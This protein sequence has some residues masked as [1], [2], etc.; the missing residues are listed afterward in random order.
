MERVKVFTGKGMPVK[1]GVGLFA[2]AFMNRFPLLPVEEEG[3]L[4]DPGLRENFIER[5][6]AMKDWRDT[7]ARGKTH[8]NLFGFHSRYKLLLLAHSERHARLLDR[9]VADAKSTRPSELYARYRE[10]FMAA[11]R[12]RATVRKNINVLRHTMGHFRK[13]ISADEKH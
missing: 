12:L 3:R 8:A 5:I 2:R 7:L 1:K 9:I 10:N 4:H 11:I 13:Q 6:F